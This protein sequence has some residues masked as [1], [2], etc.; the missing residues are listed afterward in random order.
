MVFGFDKKVKNKETRYEEESD[1]DSR[2]ILD[3]RMMNEDEDFQEPKEKKYLPKQDILDENLE[4]ESFDNGEEVKEDLKDLKKEQKNK[5]E[6]LE[7]GLINA[8]QFY[9]NVLK[10]HNQVLEELM[11]RNDLMEERIKSLESLLF[12]MRIRMRNI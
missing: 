7:E 1:I 2:D 5:E 12:R 11:K 3:D 8:L 9:D 10:E 6:N 4:E